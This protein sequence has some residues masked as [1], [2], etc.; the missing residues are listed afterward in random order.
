[1]SRRLLYVCRSKNASQAISATESP[2]TTHA[3][4]EIVA[5]E[6]I[7]CAD[8]AWP[9]PQKSHSLRGDP[10]SHT[11]LAFAPDNRGLSLGYRTPLSAA[12]PRHVVR[13]GLTWRC[14]SQ[15]V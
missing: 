14:S 4:S 10:K 12:R 1:M 3:Y 15:G 11:S 9:W 2:A 8:R 6:G 7:V 5:A 13:S